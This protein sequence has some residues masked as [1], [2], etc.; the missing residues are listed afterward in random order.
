MA[1][2]EIRISEVRIHRLDAPLTEPF[3]WSL[4]WTSRRTATLV[5]V[6][7]DAG[8]TGWGDGYFGGDVLRAHPE[9]VIGQ[10]P[11]EATRI[12]D[13]LR[14]FVWKQ[15]RTGASVCGGL[16][17]ALWD[18][19]GQAL[20]LPVSRLFGKVW[21]DRVEPYCTALYR[22]NWADLAGGLA[23]EAAAWKRLGYRTLKMKIGYG[24]DV[25]VRN[26]AA[27]REAIG[28]AIG[29]AVDANCAYDTATAAMLG[30][31]LEPFNLLWLEE[32]VLADNLSGY[33]RLRDAIRIPLAGG[34]TFDA[35]RL[36]RDYV[37]PRLVDILQPEVEIIGLTGARRLMHS[38]WLRDI[39]VIPHNWGTAVRTAAILHW[40]AACA[41]ITEALAAPPPLFEFDRTESPF[42]D[43]VI[44]E[45]I[46]LEDDGTVAVPTGPGLGVHV[47]P[48]A[49]AKYRTELITL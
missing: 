27:V 22:K 38:C 44:A 41:P 25:D 39:R 36:E 13:S 3:G 37:E 34:E 47:I 9:L 14:P 11:F 40:M 32:P 45:K 35:D 28:P 20:G 46:C 12:Y 2:T 24:P 48:D 29:L 42:R 15:A 1:L 43:A 17:T 33:R 6:R 5:E 10:S 18:L 26:V 23:E 4:G 30:H 16:D 31:R 21:R 49:V 7:T 19:M 8:L